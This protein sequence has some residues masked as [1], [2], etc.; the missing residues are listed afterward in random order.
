MS[1]LSC[2]TVV[3]NNNYD[4]YY[5]N[6]IIILDLLHKYEEGLDIT[7]ELIDFLVINNYINIDKIFNIFQLS[8]D[9][10]IK[11]CS[12][13]LRYNI[14]IIS[15]IAQLQLQLDV[16]KCDVLPILNYTKNIL[17]NGV[18][19]TVSNIVVRED[20]GGKKYINENYINELYCILNELYYEKICN[21]KLLSEYNCSKTLTQFGLT[22]ND[23]QPEL[24]IEIVDLVENN[25]YTQFVITLIKKFMN[26][27]LT[28]PPYIIVLYIAENKI[29]ENPKLVDIVI[30]NAI[31]ISVIMS[32][33]SD[34]N[35]SPIDY[36][37]YDYTNQLA[38]IDNDNSNFI[39]IIK[40]FIDNLNRYIHLP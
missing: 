33:V 40:L 18:I 28:I 13:I 17:E 34:F 7:D 37:I 23:L 2:T 25:N 12:K 10:K 19:N 32:N 36:N 22:Y 16:R 24:F 11:I 27:L 14:I 38:K 8:N 9:N 39:F 30:H 20:C 5:D 15:D 35:I 4:Y 31:K 26:G 6:D 1:L 29:E 3:E 21:K